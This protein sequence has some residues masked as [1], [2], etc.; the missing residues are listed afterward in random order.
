MMGYHINAQNK[1]MLDF[2]ARHDTNFDVLD[3]MDLTTRLGIELPPM[4]YKQDYKESDISVGV[5]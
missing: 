4:K 5:A 3:N 2:A 1:D